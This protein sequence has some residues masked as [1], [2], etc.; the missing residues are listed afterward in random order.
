VASPQH[1]GHE[2]V[3]ERRCH[4]V[5]ATAEPATGSVYA[6]Y[7][8]WRSDSPHRP[9]PSPHEQLGLLERGGP[10]LMPECEDIDSS[11]ANPLSLKT[12]RILLEPSDH[13]QVDLVDVF[14]EPLIE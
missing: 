10:L 2:S 11:L 12:L 6:V 13:R 1:K 4:A 3:G 7:G 14:A 9:L 8:S 5:S